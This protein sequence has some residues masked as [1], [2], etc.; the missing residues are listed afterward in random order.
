MASNITLFNVMIH[1]TRE[2]LYLDSHLKCSKP[3]VHSSLSVGLSY[4][5]CIIHFGS[6][7]HWVSKYPVGIYDW[8][9]LF[10]CGP[11]ILGIALFFVH[12]LSC[13]HSSLFLL[14]FLI[15]IVLLCDITPAVAFVCVIGS[16]FLL[17]LLLPSLPHVS[18]HLLVASKD[19]RNVS[20]DEVRILT[21]L[22]S[23]NNKS[24]PK[25][26]MMQKHN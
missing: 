13:C 1:L 16:C 10:V 14:S 19:L 4:M 21:V 2:F 25:S 15:L 22:C 5:I 17:S 20:M 11:L 9:Q 18:S 12:L 3:L 6:L 23:Q 26:K 7:T 8:Y 24:R